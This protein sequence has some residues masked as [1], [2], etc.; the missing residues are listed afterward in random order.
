MNIFYRLTLNTFRECV[1][2]PQLPRSRSRDRKKANS[3]LMVSP[4]AVVRKIFLYKVY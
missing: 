1:R 2:G 4:L 3:R